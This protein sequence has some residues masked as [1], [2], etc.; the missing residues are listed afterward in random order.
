LFTFKYYLRWST[1]NRTEL[2]NKA[3]WVQT[4]YGNG[5]TE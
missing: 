2:D 1:S 5:R 3:S 4:P